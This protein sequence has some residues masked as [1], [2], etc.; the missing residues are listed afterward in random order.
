MEYARCS[1]NSTVAQ[2]ENTQGRASKFR[3]IKV[4]FK[5]QTTA[6]D[7]K[8]HVLTIQLFGSIRKLMSYEYTPY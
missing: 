6:L 1:K 3:V 8:W 5:E 7:P 2:S 4:T